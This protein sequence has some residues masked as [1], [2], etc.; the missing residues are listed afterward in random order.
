M[1]EHYEEKIEEIREKII[2]PIKAKIRQKVERE[3]DEKYAKDVLDLT[4]C[5]RCLVP[6]PPADDKLVAACTLKGLPRNRNHCVIKAEVDFEKKFGHKPDLNDDEE[7]L[8][9]KILAQDQLEQ[10]RERVFNENVSEEKKAEMNP[11]EIL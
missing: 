7:V 6:V 2:N 10:L 4:P 9:L 8:Q 3:F 11:E 1:I 5:Y